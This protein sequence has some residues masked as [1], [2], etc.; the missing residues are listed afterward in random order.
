VVQKFLK[1]LGA[2]CKF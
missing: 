2:T 1:N